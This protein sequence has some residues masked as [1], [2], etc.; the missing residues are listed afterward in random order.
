MD[1]S[2]IH[3][4]GVYCRGIVLYVKEGIG[5]NNRQAKSKA[6]PKYTKKVDINEASIGSTTM[7]SPRKAGWN[8]LILGLVLMLIPFP[9]F[10]IYIPLFLA[11]FIMSII[12]MSKDDIE[13]GIVLLIAVCILPGI[14]WLIGIYIMGEMI[15]K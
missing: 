10:W 5:T 6:H 13:N 14:F 11:T 8:C 4:F 1:V 2:F 9:L 7:E 15:F 3:V 12:T